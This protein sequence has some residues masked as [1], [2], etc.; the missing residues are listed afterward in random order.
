MSIWTHGN[1]TLTNIVIF[2]SIQQNMEAFYTMLMY[3]NLDS[4]Y[5]VM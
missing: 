5:I 1:D 2:F 4:N 3:V